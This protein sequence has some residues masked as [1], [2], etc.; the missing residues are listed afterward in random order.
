M[1]V[2]GIFFSHQIGFTKDRKFQE[3][4]LKI[5]DHRPSPVI[6]VVISL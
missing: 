2:S 5:V 4:Y 1:M 3:E 6:V